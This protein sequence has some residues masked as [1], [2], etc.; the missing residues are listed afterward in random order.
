V[1]VDPSVGPYDSLGIDLGF[2]ATVL[3]ADPA[4]SQLKG[5]WD[6]PVPPG[7]AEDLP[8][9]LSFAAIN[10]EPVDPAQLPTL[11]TAGF[12]W[13]EGANG[14]MAADGFHL[15]VR[16]ENQGVGKVVLEATQ[17]FVFKPAVLGGNATGTAGVDRFI[18]GGGD[19]TVTGAAGNDVFVPMTN[20]VNLTIQDFATG[21]DKIDLGRLIAALG[22]TATGNGGDAT[23]KVL[24]AW[25]GQNLPTATQITNAD[26]SLDNTCWFSYDSANR[27]LDLFM[28][29]RP[30]T[31]EVDIAHL[32][33]HFG[34]A[35]TGFNV[36]DLL[37]SP[38]SNGPVL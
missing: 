20:R 28:D 2:N 38:Y 17:D 26:P 25:T 9:T 33:I 8:N 22:Y 13:K 18:L 35:S 30:N 19:V 34:S 14:P 31:S 4:G 21:E 23:A 27:H 16:L 11:A 10:L 5:S 29:A 7:L 6:M 36:K 12:V 15:Q 37:L 24:S 3:K 1:Q 32:G